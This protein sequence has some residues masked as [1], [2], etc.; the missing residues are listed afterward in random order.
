MKV[1]ELIEILQLAEK[2]FK[3]IHPCE[4]AYVFDI[5]EYNVGSDMIL[6]L[7]EK[8][9]EI[10]AEFCR[11]KKCEEFEIDFSY[12]DNEFYDRSIVVVDYDDRG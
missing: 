12:D 8:P 9:I 6:R 7:S 11:I 4:D 5:D 3:M 10:R 1:K 2:K